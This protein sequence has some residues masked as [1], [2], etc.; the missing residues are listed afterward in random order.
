[1]VASRVLHHEFTAVVEPPNDDDQWWIAY[2]P[3]VPG[4]NGQGASETEAIDSLREAIVL[5]LQTRLEEGLR[6]VPADAKQTT[7][8]VG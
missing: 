3:E 1:M 5:I 4:A 2:C 7:V 8:K 6:S